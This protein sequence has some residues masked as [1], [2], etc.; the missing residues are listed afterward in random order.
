MEISQVI[1]EEVSKVDFEKI[2]KDEVASSLET[3]VNNKVSD[4]F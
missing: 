3:L 1:N 4:L 2:I